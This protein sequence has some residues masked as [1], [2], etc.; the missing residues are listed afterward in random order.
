MIAVIRAKSISYL[1][2]FGDGLLLLLAFLL[3]NYSAFG[4]NQFPNIDSFGGEAWQTAL[5]C[6]YGVLVIGLLLIGHGLHREFISMVSKSRPLLCFLFLALLSLSWTVSLH[7]TLYELSFLFFSTFAAAYFALRYRLL[8]VINI[9]TWTAAVAT[10]AG[11]TLALFTPYGVMPNQPFT[12]SWDGMF[13]HRNHAGS[14]M[15]FF[16]MLFLVRLLMDKQGFPRRLF[17][18]L[19][20]VLTAIHVFNSRSAAGILV[21]IFLNFSTLI[22]FGWISFR[23]KLKSWHYYTFVFTV[24]SGFMIFVTNLGFFFGLLG[25]S[26]T[27]TG[28][29]PLWEDLLVNV[30]P[31]RPILGHGFG[32]IWMQESF[33]VFMQHRQGWGHP[34]YFA[35]NGFLDILLNLGVVGL[36]SFLIIF[37]FAGVRALTQLHSTRSWMYILMVLALFYVFAGNLAYSFLME[38]DYFVWMVFVMVYILVSRPFDGDAVTV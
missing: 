31:A 18:G 12:G 29:T 20:Y 19:F 7:A 2:G 10:V 5:G 6:F 9:L 8:G 38:V 30:F 27:M 34:I 11:F 25:R 23:E 15:A 4:S 3:S 32:V 17:F 28:R 37:G 33:R 1:K 24:F 16:N 13:W 21:F 22:A 14:L 36:I 35:D 26:S